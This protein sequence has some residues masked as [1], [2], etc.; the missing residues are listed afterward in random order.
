MSQRFFTPIAAAAAGGRLSWTRQEASNGKQIA[1][2]RVANSFAV[3]GTN[4]TKFQ[5][6]SNTLLHPDCGNLESL[7]NYS[8]KVP[9]LPLKIT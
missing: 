6:R 1:G 4:G 7:G 5:L 8:P 9:Y 3:L 2:G